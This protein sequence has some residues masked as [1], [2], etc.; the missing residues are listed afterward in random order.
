MTAV[1][2][3]PW[4]VSGML[5]A[6]TSGLLLHLIPNRIL[7]II[8]SLCSIAACLFFALMPP[9]DSPSFSYWA[10]V[11]PAMIA[12]TAFIDILYT[13]SNVFITTR[14]PRRH[15]GLAGALINCT[16][17]IGMCF[18]LGVAEVAVAATADRGLR[19][20]YQVAFWIAVG[21]GC[22]TVLVFAFMDIGEAKSDLT[23]DEKRARRE[24]EAGSES[25]EGES[26]TG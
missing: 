19:G 13:L 24:A 9:R 7:L 22:V 15:L 26:N 2:Y 11:F 18:F 5:F 16:L 8:S 12:E 6:A 17:Y 4:A 3:T 21:F 1:W 10:Y 14:L 25:N 23:E 20:S